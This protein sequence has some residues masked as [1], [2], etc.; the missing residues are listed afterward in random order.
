MKT[1]DNPMPDKTPIDN[2]RLLL[3]GRGPCWIPFSL[4]VGCQPGFSEPIGRKF[5]SLTEADDPA[6][7]FDSDFRRF[8]LH[9]SYG[10]GDPATLH[11]SVEPGTKFD[12]WGNGHWA[13]GQE[14]TVDKTYPALAFTESVRDVEALP[15]P[16]IDGSVDTSPIE[17]QHAAGYPVFGYGGSI[18]EW[19]WWVRGMER[20]MIDMVSDTKLAE[21]IIHKIEAHTTRL[22]TATARAGI[23]VVCF[24]DDVGMQSGMQIAPELWR[25]FIKPAWSRVLE[26]VRGEAPGTGFFLHS[27]GKIEPIIPDII[28]LGFHILHPLQP[29]CMDFEALHREYGRDIVLTA[30]MS[31]QKIFPFGSPDDVR[32]EVRR[33]AE[34]VGADRRCILMPSNVIQP[35]TPWENIVAFAEEAR[36]LRRGGESC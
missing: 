29:E 1:K 13:G 35:E 9:A 7:Y 20:F 6:A 32:Q 15:S 28:D 36:A 11:E 17:A 33:L 14:G 2:L 34:L 18:Y 22:A 26:A 30:T 24:Y 31:S 10:G 3:D 8:S 5:R 25:R 12:E 21:A 16:V 19:S 23:D 4:D 27:C